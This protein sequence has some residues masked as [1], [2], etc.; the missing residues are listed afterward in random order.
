[1]DTQARPEQDSLNPS[2][3]ASVSDAIPPEA[4]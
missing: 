3:N 1:M 4:T 2:A